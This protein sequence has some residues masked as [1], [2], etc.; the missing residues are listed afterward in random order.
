MAR[1]NFD[2]QF[3]LLIVGESGVGKSCILLRFADDMFESDC[4]STIGVDFKVRELDLEGRRVKLQ[5]WDSA[6]QERFR[7]ITSS[8][9]RNASAVII[10]YD[11]TSQDS[12]DKVAGWIDEVR[13]HIQVPL[14]I[15]GNKCDLVERRQVTTEAGTEFAQRQGLIFMETSA[16]VNTNIEEAFRQLSKQLVDAELAKPKPAET[17]GNVV[18]N[19]TKTPKKKKKFC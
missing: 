7:N 4:L 13:R 17:P 6:G 5:I 8:Y 3:R 2:H 15:V 11:V 1:A 12:F 14:L 10:V 9:Y 16:K 18:L 19:P